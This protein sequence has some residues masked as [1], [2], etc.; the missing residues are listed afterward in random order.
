LEPVTALD[1]V[2]AEGDNNVSASTLVLAD[3]RRAWGGAGAYHSPNADVNLWL[4]DNQTCSDFLLEP[5]VSPETLIYLVPHWSSA[6]AGDATVIKA[7]MGSVSVSFPLLAP[8][9]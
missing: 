5:V 8:L 3:G 2:D 7:E 6:A 4:L 9:P 1:L